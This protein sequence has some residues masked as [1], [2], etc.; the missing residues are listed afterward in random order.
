MFDGWENFFLMAGGAAAVLIG[1][2]FVVISLMQDRPR[3]Q[4]LGGAKLYMGPIVLGLSFLLALSGAALAPGIDAPDFAIIIGVIALWGLWRGIRSTIGI[5]RLKEVQWTDVWF[6]GVF[7]SA[8][9]VGFAAVASA[10]WTNAH[11]ARPSLAAVITLGL[12]L[13]IRN[14]WDLITWITPQAE[15]GGHGDDLSQS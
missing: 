14:E 10:F 3:S 8:V 4:V 2:I 15:E 7:P 13:A 9:Y 1:L 6:Y 5:A 12:L 11:W